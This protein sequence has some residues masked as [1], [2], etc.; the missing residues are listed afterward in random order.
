MG[1]LYIIETAPI[2]VGGDNF[3]IQ[4]PLEGS[5]KSF[6]CGQQLLISRTY[7]TAANLPFLND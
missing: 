4:I 2:P 6:Y 1:L 5:L 3:K 7:I